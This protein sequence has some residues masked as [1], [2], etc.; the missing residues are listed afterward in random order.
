MSQASFAYTSE[1]NIEQAMNKFLLF[2]SLKNN[3]IF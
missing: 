1:G 2:F 3:L